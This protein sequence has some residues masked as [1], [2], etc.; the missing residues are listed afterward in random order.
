M[1]SEMSSEELRRRR[2]TSREA[3]AADTARIGAAASAGCV[4]VVRRSPRLRCVIAR[5]AIFDD[6][7][8]ATLAELCRLRRPRF[9]VFSQS[10][11]FSFC[12]GDSFEP[13]DGALTH[14][15]R[16]RRSAVGGPRLQPSERS[17]C[18][19]ARGTVPEVGTPRP[20]SHG[21]RQRRGGVV[22]R[23]QLCRFADLAALALRTAS[24]RRVR[25][26][27]RPVPQK[28]ALR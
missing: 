12:F 13:A 19:C 4:A 25:L 9:T 26:E 18:R 2:L 10:G 20:L 11:V 6:S 23:G 14:S 28:G 5:N 17:F 8:L 7:F 24:D 3:T 1:V 27:S 21:R 16:R 15:T 22:D